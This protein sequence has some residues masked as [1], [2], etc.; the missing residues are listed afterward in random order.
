LPKAK[1]KPQG[2]IPSPAELAARSRVLKTNQKL[3]DQFG[4]TDAPPRELVAVAELP[5]PP[6]TETMEVVQSRRRKAEP[7]VNVDEAVMN[8]LKDEMTELGHRLSLFGVKF[9]A[10]MQQDTTDHVFALLGGF[11]QGGGA[12]SHR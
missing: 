3:A 10:G 1:A 5:D 8:I 7:V 11:V 2:R 4:I 9:D 12:I 6:S